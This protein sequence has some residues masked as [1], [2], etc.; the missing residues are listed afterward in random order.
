MEICSEVKAHGFTYSALTQC[1]PIELS[2]I[3]E[4]LSICSFNTVAISYM[5]LLSIQN[6]AS[7]TEQMNF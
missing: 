7:V 5:W 6:V 3:M 2:E 4:I 1:S